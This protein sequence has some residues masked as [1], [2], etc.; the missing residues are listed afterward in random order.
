MRWPWCCCRTVT[1]RIGVD[2]ASGPCQ[3]GIAVPARRAGRLRRQRLRRGG[4]L[5][6]SSGR[7]S[8]PAS[9]PRRRA[10]QPSWP[11]TWC[12]PSSQKS[13]AATYCGTEGGDWHGGAPDTRAHHAGRPR[14]LGL[15]D[16]A[17]RRRDGALHRARRAARASS[18]RSASASG[19]IRAQRA[20]LPRRAGRARLPRAA[21]TAS[22]ATRRRPTSSSTS[23]SRPTSAASSRWRTPP[24]RLLGQP[25]R[26]AAHRR[27]AERGEERRHAASSTRST[28]TPH[29][30]SSSSRAMTGHQPRR[31][32]RDRRAVP[33]GGLQDAS[34]TSAPPR[35]T[36]PSRSRSRNPHL[37]GIGFDLP[38]VGPIFEDYVAAN[39]LA[40]RVC[41]RGRRLLRRPA[42][43]GGRHH[44]G[45]HPPRLEPRAEED[46]HRQGLRR[47]AGRRRAD[48]LRGDHR[49]RPLARTP[50][51]CS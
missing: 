2:C 7:R 33:V 31:Q 29:G 4:R 51:A 12:S 13:R 41:V 20:R 16:A 15:E 32:P 43:A 21:R 3:T 22:T 50:S 46:A 44:D 35:A 10:P 45:P 27:A 39:G 38:E 25:H 34:S 6:G 9:P 30:S 48:R 37:A 36:W 11:S 28:P 24:L 17:E 8:R 19:S 47:P 18:R 49:R 1:P 26:G 42:P 23:A 5:S 40:E 14:L